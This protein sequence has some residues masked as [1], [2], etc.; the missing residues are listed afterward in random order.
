MEYARE[1]G[2]TETVQGERTT[3]QYTNLGRLLNVELRTHRSMVADQPWRRPTIFAVG[4][5]LT[6]GEV[7]L[8]TVLERA[9]IRR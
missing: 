4:V 9:N 3:T 5:T 7:R 8:P 2:L 6:I 1:L